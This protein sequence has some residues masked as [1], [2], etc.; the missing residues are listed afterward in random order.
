MKKNVFSRFLKSAFALLFVLSVIFLGNIKTLEALICNVIGEGTT[1]EPVNGAC[2]PGSFDPSTQSPTGTPSS[3]GNQSNEQITGFL[4]LLARLGNIINNIIPFLVGLAVFIIIFGILGYISSAANEEKR[5]EAKNFIL[6]GVIGVFLMLS[7][8]GLV[9]ILLNTFNLNNSNAIVTQVYQPFNGGQATKNPTT[10]L[11]LIDRMNSI[12]S[13]L[14][15]FFIGIGVFI[16]IIGI[17]GYIRQADNEEK[18]AEARMFILWGVLSIFFM[19]S[20]WGM[21]NIL[22]NTFNL[23]NAL[24]TI[25]NLPKL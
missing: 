7:V 8:W 16:I 24:P 11:E 12:G 17:L 15:P 18:R 14:I 21:V 23:N 2:P 13:R 3:A 1:V 19:L 22:L 25:P 6:W 5:T 4:G 20:I 9:T 10:I